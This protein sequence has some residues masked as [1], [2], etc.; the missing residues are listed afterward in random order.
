MTVASYFRDLRQSMV[1]KVYKIRYVNEF[2][3]KQKR[4]E[5]VEKKLAEIN[6]SILPLSFKPTPDGM[7]LESNGTFIQCLVIGRLTPKYKDRQDY[8]NTLDP[9]LVS[10]ILNIGTTKETSIS[11]THIIYPLAPEQENGALEKARRSIA[12]SSAMQEGEDKVLHAH[13]R[14][15]D[16]AAEDLD[17]YHRAVYNGDTKLYHYVLLVAIQGVSK[18]SVEK[19]MNLIE[20]LLDSKR[21]LH[22]RP[23]KG[24]KETYDS[25][26]PTPRVWS[27]LFKR[28]VKAEL[29]ATT[30]LLI[31]PNPL[32]ADSGRFLGMNEKTGNPIF[33]N[34]KD[35]SSICG[36][37]LE[38][39]M[40][41]SGKTTDLLKDDIRAYLD[42]DN[43]IHIVPK[44]DGLTNHLR[45]CEAFNGQLIKVGHGGTNFNI[46][47]V[48]FDPSV[49]DT[50]VDGYNAAFLSHYTHL[51]EC[52]GLLVG[53][54]YTD[55]QKNWLNQ[56]LTA[57]Y[58]DFHVIDEK[59]D[60]IQGNVER[61]QDG[62]F[63]PNLRDMRNVFKT[64]LEDGKHKDPSAA[65]PI[66]ALFANTSLLETTLRYLVNNNS[67]M[68]DNQMIMADIS[69]LSDVPNVQEAIT[70]MLMSIVY[71]KMTNTRPGAN[72][73]RTLLTLDEGADLVKNKTMEKNI[74][75]FFR[76][77]R[78]WGLY[79]KIVSQDLAGFP[80]SMLEMIKTNTDYILLF[81]NMR[82]D[83]VLSL[84]KE[85][86]LDED[87]VARLLTPGARRGIM[88]IG[89]SHLHYFN[90][91]DE[92][93]EYI[94]FGKD[95]LKFQQEKEEQDTGLKIAPEVQHIVD[96]YHILSKEWIIDFTEHPSGW[97]R[98]KGINPLTGNWTTVYYKKSLI[99][100]NGLFKNQTQD[101][102][103]SACLLA[104]ELSRK[105]GAKCTLDD[106]GKAEYAED[107][108]KQEADVVAVFAL[109]NN[110][111]TTIA[112]E[113]ETKHH[114]ISKK[115]LQGK[116]DRLEAKQ[117][118]TS[119]RYC[120]D[121]VI[122]FAA[123]DHIEFLTD[124]LGSD[125]AVQRGTLLDSLIEQK[126][127]NKSELL[128]PPQ[129][130]T[131]VAEA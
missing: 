88:I 34:F 86:N 125:Y 61:W 41:G 36:H 4:D 80:P 126:L 49:M 83:N 131:T 12:I 31:N 23:I 39:G 46:L 67:L 60:V 97:E 82:P 26:M 25:M 11:M 58:E 21:V 6:D 15:N 30:S 122:F 42:G 129:A 118:N 109:P 110:R 117:M 37:A 24:M 17:E 90:D 14:T 43:V 96:N 52:I 8:P 5:E 53:S 66:G 124:A 121:K 79:I 100:E 120:F 107:G 119:D 81:G 68:L 70:M 103:F 73:L 32:L 106:F 44:K 108:T 63:W 62:N 94:I 76:Q 35:P 33:F 114:K 47:Q 98:A 28:S 89:G 51:L 20:T 93:E 50:S 85:F 75:K 91:M 55:Q 22:E 18:A 3:K 130:Q 71:T 111:E 127:R 128:Q 57:L 112:F 19:T 123:K 40:S 99:G 9:R 115:A 116:R 113:Y 104:G 105:Y 64:W 45:V 84:K 54:G 95:A 10:D 69:A 16:F 92:N 101:H 7:Y 27:K 13:D 102:Y 48:F 59:G 72:A 77:G 56:A 87:D 1:N 38:I 74:E 29:C 78:A 2:A 65:G